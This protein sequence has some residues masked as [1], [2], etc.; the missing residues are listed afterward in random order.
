M[1]KYKIHRVED[2]VLL[3]NKD[4]I[5]NTTQAFGM[6]T[7]AGVILLHEGLLNGLGINIDFANEMM[8]SI[9]GLLTGVGVLGGSISTYDLYKINKEI[10]N[11]IDAY[12]NKNKR[13]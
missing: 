4:I 13:R 9:G 3:E 1:K 5:V 11:N 8:T 6:T 7:L 12:D 10:K 2:V